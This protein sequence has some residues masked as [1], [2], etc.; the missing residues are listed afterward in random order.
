MGY[1]KNG[2]WHTGEGGFANEDGEFVRHTSEFRDW[3]TA[4]G[5]EGPDGAKG[6][7]AE[8]GRYHLY[9]SYACPWAHRALIMRALKGLDDMIGLSVT[10][11]LMGDQ[12]WTFDDGP[13]VIQDPNEGAKTIHELYQIAEPEVSGKATVPVLW[14]KQT[15]SIVSN[16]SSEI[17][18][19]LN[20]A[21][22][23]V[24]AKEGDYYPEHLQSE[25]DAVNERVYGSFNNGVY[26]AGFA[27]SQ[28]HYEEAV[29]DVFGTLDW[30][31]DYLTDRDW[32]VGDQMTEA[33]IRFFTTLLRFDPVYHG[34]FKCNRYK[35][36]EVDSLRRYRARMLAIP[37]VRS[38]V[39]LDHIKHHYYE[40]HKHVNPTG[41]VPLGPDMPDLE[42]A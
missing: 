36:S 23:G 8:P 14:D 37:E 33:D 15:R 6:Y 10:N 11:W 22:D 24:G 35:V 38:T 16:E 42:K 3:I 32:L 34:H 2:K 1:L 5:S 13:G 17:I 25:I 31:S 39:H 27:E 21:F 29:T 18:R 12:G 41:I 30:A 26:R 20:T 7:K 19:M 9:V 28:D 40:S 4:D